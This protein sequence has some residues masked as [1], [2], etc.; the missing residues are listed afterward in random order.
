[1]ERL[2][3]ATTISS[4]DPYLSD[5]R[6]AMANVTPLQALLVVAGAAALGYLFTWAREA[7]V[8]AVTAGVYAIPFA[9]S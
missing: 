5:L 7:L 3:F 1:M 2:S 8:I 4:L 9:F 6:A